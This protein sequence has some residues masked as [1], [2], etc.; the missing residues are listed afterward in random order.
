MATLWA[1]YMSPP[2]ANRDALR[3]KLRELGV[4]Q[5]ETQIEADTND[6]DTDG[7]DPGNLSTPFTP[8]P[9]RKADLQAHI[10]AVSIIYCHLIGKLKGLKGK[11]KQDYKDRKKHRHIKLQRLLSIRETNSATAKVDC[12]DRAIEE[13]ILDLALKSMAMRD[14]AGGESSKS[15]NNTGRIH[16][17]CDNSDRSGILSRRFVDPKPRSAGVLRSGIPSL[18]SREVKAEDLN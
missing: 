1:E 5:S 16:S 3:Q 15:S 4:L 12:D 11:P 18:L 2:T 6:Q 13:E 8:S 14:A 7:S 10:D 17:V 9:G